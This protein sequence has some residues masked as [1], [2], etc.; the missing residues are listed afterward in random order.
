MIKTFKKFTAVFLALVMI[1]SVITATTVNATDAKDTNVYYKIPDFYTEKFGAVPGEA[2]VN[3]HVYAVNGTDPDFV[4]YGYMTKAE[5]CVYNE[6]TGLYSYDLAEK[7]AET[8]LKDNALYVVKFVVAPSGPYPN[9]IGADLTMGTDCM[10]DTVYT[11]EDTDHAPQD[12]PSDMYTSYWT[13]NNV[14]YFPLVQLG[15][16]DSSGELNVLDASFVQMEV[17]KFV[18]ETEV[19]MNFADMNNDKVIG[20]NDATIIQMKVAKLI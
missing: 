9:I 5:K 14:K 1:L 12:S 19:D 13:E 7:F 8:P 6:E 11:V 3:C 16:V 10:G 17:A 18:S 20:I 15:D 4:S 2:T